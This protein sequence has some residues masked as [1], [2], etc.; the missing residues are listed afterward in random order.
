MK[1]RQVGMH[2]S[3]IVRDND[4]IHGG[5]IYCSHNLASLFFSKTINRSTCSHYQIY[6]ANQ[7]TSAKTG[8]V[9]SQGP[10]HGGL[11]Q[12]FVGKNQELRYCERFY[13]ARSLTREFQ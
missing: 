3:F 10:Q 8:C 9:G 6:H 1:P 13:L 5:G 4:Y 7:I 11:S 2:N 12:N